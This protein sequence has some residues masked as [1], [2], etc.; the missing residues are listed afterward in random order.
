MVAH[1][2]H[3]DA[4]GQLAVVAVLLDSGRPNPLLSATWRNLP[5]DKG[6]EFTSSHV[7][8][9]PAQL[10]PSGRKY[11]TFRGSLTTPPCS[12]HVRWFVLKSPASISTEQ[13]AIFGKHYPSNA[14][15]VQPLNGRVVLSDS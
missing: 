15:P 6:H 1:L 14:R 13:L 7:T 11:Y 9:N 4:K 2:V 10:L 12:E 8:V 5:R 3:R